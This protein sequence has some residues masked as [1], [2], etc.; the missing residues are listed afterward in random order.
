MIKRILIF[1]LCATFFSACSSTDTQPATNPAADKTPT[2]VST[3]NT[4]PAEPETAANDTATD[5]TGVASCDEYLTEVEK[6]VN[7][8]KVPQAVRDSYKQSLE[9]NRTAWKQAA[10]TPEGKAALETGCI[11]ALDS[12]KPMFEKYGK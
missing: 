10:S 1:T 5:L 12:A 9:Q 3:E 2:A 11:A 8:Q 6:F 4:T 7:N